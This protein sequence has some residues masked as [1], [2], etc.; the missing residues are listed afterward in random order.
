MAILVDSFL[1]PLGVHDVPPPPQ[2]AQSKIRELEGKVVEER[3][4]VQQEKKEQ[5]DQI[6]SL[7]AE[8]KSLSDKIERWVWSLIVA[9]VVSDSRGHG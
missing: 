4:K 3:N 5:S 7:K 2:E 6:R 9:G 8:I 1:L